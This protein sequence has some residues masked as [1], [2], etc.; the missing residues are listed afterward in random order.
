D[1]GPRI[2]PEVRKRQHRGNRGQQAH[3][4]LRPRRS[5]E[6]AGRV[7]DQRVTQP[8]CSLSPPICGPAQ[9]DIPIKWAAP[10]FTLA[11]SIVRLWLSRPC[12]VVQKRHIV[13]DRVAAQRTAS[14]PEPARPSQSV[15]NDGR[16]RTCQ[17]KKTYRRL[18]P[19]H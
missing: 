19:C 3:D 7:R 10:F 11:E 8:A 9:A 4:R 1:R 17:E 12:N 15:R 5:E 6:G 14:D 13:V 16:I 18:L 2:P